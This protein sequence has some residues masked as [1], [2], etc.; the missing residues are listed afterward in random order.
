MNNQQL[1][2]SIVLVMILSGGA[3][4]LGK[5]KSAT[6]QQKATLEANNNTII[7]IGAGMVELSS[8]DFKTILLER[9]D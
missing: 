6:P 7:Q 3:Y 1:L 9:E 4:Y 5:D 8:K 2:S